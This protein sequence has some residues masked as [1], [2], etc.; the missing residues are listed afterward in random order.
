MP[1]VAIDEDICTFVQ[2]PFIRALVHRLTPTAVTPNQVT[3]LRALLGVA[4]GLLL[5]TGTPQLLGLSALCLILSGILDGVDGQLAAAKGCASLSGRILDGAADV[6][7]FGAMQI[8]IYCHARP[9]LEEAGWAGDGGLALVVLAVS[10]LQLIGFNFWDYHKNRMRRLTGDRRGTVHRPRA[11]Q[12]LLQ[13]GGAAPR[14]VMLRAY[15]GYCRIQA[16]LSRD[17]RPIRVWPSD[18]PE[19]A[20]AGRAL[21]PVARGWSYLGQTTSE[22]VFA[23]VVLIAAFYPLFTSYFLL[24]LM[25]LLPPYIVAMRIWTVAVDGRLRAAGII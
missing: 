14:R 22:T 1:S 5:A 20:L 16:L 3:L 25:I 9:L 24:G 18:G 17:Q 15:L 10:V 13:Q 7:V 11:V 12:E 2:R 23:T 19:A 21:R 4:S 8:G 6:L